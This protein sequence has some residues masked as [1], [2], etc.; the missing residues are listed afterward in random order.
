MKRSDILPPMPLADD[1]SNFRIG[2][3]VTNEQQL[4]TS[5]AEYQ[6]QLRVCSL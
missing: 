1:F 4:T 2:H 5:I 6:A 3:S